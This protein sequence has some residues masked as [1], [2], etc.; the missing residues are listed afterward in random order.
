MRAPNT[1]GILGYLLAVGIALWLNAVFL[2]ADVMVADGRWQD[3]PFALIEVVA[4]EG[5]LGTMIAAVGVLVLHV[6]CRRVRWQTVHVLVA[7]GLGYLAGAGLH[8]WIGDSAGDSAT[9]IASLPL[10]IG[11]A[12][13]LGRLAVV[14]V[15]L[16]QR[17]RF[18]SQPSLRVP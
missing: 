10:Y 7:A 13:G 15:V 17:R 6:T 8:A 11:S 2:V 16:A 9:W 4:I 12:A 1:P 3:L 18:A 14:P 5:F